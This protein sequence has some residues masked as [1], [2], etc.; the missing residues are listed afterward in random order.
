MSA[1]LN[2]SA[3][4]VGALLS[5]STFEVPAYQ[6]EYAWEKAQVTEFWSDLSGAIGK[7]PYFLGLL[8]FTGTDKRKQVVDGQQRLLTITLL[9]AALR[10]TALQIGRKALADQI[11]S[12]LL[13]SMDYSTDE[14]VPRIVLTDRSANDTL[15]AIVDKNAIELESNSQGSSSERLSAAYRILQEELLKA[16]NEDT[17]RRLGSW[18]EFINEHLYVAIF[19]HPDE[20]AAYSVFEV[21]N[22]RGRQLTTADL[23]KNYVLRH[24]PLQE[25]DAQYDRWTKLTKRF[26]AFGGHNFV[27]YIQHVINLNAGYVLP[28]DLYNYIARRGSYSSNHLSTESDK[29]AEVEVLMTTLEEHL[30]LY[31]QLLDPTSDGPADPEA[32]GV[33]AALNE[34]GVSA[35]RP[36]MLAI[37]S[38]DGDAVTGMKETLRIIVRKIVV[39]NL[40]A[41]SAER[42]FAEAAKTVHKT[43]SW[44]QGIS[45]LRDMNHAREEFVGQLTNRSLNRGVLTFIR[46][47]IICQS[48]T[49]DP[50][51]TLQY[52]RPR[53]SNDNSWPGFSDEEQ[54]FWGS[55]LGNTILCTLDRRPRGASTWEGVKAHLLPKAVQGEFKDPLQT[56]SAWTPKSVRQVGSDLAKKAADVWYQ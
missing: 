28:K 8:V 55:T 25:R 48:I 38:T 36:L 21:V 27:Q 18:A 22:T 26:E 20:A 12:T 43:K 30:G 34:L 23:L 24:T 31:I 4:T 32:L 6:R 39:G 35:V 9:A 50:I 11:H 29:E 3:T 37:A 49:P 13:R 15:Q 1:P 16:G 56:I 33:F 44:R 2:A 14:M 17:F 46:R 10:H 51:G 42:K 5:S 41:N 40:G 53:Q 19:E 47:S 45:S 7:G 54:S 52:L